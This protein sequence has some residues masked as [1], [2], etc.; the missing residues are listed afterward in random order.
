MFF[1]LLFSRR[2]H[3]MYKDDRTGELAASDTRNDTRTYIYR[4][5]LKRPK[6]RRQDGEF[7]NLARISNG[8]FCLLLL[9]LLHHYCMTQ[10]RNPAGLLF[11]MLCRYYG[12]D[13]EDLK[14]H[15]LI[16]CVCFG[17]TKKEGQ[18]WNNGTIVNRLWDLGSFVEYTSS[19]NQSRLFGCL[20]ILLL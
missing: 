14:C 11:S 5:E 3:T 4:C 17:G 1:S 8:V 12:W 20:L 19:L 10:K 18:L 9:Y 7:G 2:D 15:L 13:G 6:R 16:L